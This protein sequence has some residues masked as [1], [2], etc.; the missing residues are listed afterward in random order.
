MTYL[1]D[2]SLEFVEVD[3]FEALE[4]RVTT[5]QI[6]E[7]W[8]QGLAIV[9]YIANNHAHGL[10]EPQRVTLEPRVTHQLLPVEMTEAENG[11]DE[12]ILTEDQQEYSRS[13]AAEVR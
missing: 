1:H 10:H 3:R 4:L 12:W 6:I 11:F 8:R 13:A 9:V 2:G 5:T 7:H